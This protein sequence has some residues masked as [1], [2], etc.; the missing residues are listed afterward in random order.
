MTTLDKRSSFTLTPK[1][2]EVLRCKADIVAV[3]GGY[4]SSK[5]TIGALL[6]LDLIQKHTWVE[7][8]GNS[9]PIFVVLAPTAS[10]LKNTTLKALLHLIP[11]EMIIEVNKNDHRYELANGVV[12]QGFTTAGKSFEGLNPIGIWLDEAHKVDD[13]GIFTNIVARYRRDAI[14]TELERPKRLFITGIPYLGSYLEDNFRTPKP[15]RATF[16]CSID[17]NPH[18]DPKQKAQTL[19]SISEDQIPTLVEG[20]WGAIPDRVFPGFSTEDHVGDYPFNPSQPVFVA[21]DPGRQYAGFLFAQVRP[22][23]MNDGTTKD[24]LFIIDEWFPEEN[25]T[26]ADVC[27]QIKQSKYGSLIKAFCIDPTARADEMNGIRLSFPSTQIE[28][29]QSKDRLAFQETGIR[30]VNRGLKDGKKNIRLFIDNSL[31]KNK[32][33]LINI[34]STYK[35]SKTTGLPSFANT[36]GDCMADCLRYLAVHLIPVETQEGSNISRSIANPFG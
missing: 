23:R 14:A 10:I 27:S 7:A 13:P 11:K 24:A 12:I 5:T 29:K 16:L 6:S 1:Q 20:K 25:A 34:L 28:R 33:G 35:R 36:Q 17:D 18:I 4:G 19:E 31:R 30:C 21:I 32:K 22:T 15:D 2:K 3:L 8:Y 9:N 26:I